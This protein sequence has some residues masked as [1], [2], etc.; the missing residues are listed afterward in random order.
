[1]CKMLVVKYFSVT[2]FYILLTLSTVNFIYYFKMYLFDLNVVF[3]THSQP[4]S[5]SLDPGLKTPAGAQHTWTTNYTRGLSSCSKH[6]LLLFSYKI[7][8][9]GA[10]IITPIITY[11]WR[12]FW[13]RKRNME[14]FSCWSLWRAY[15]KMFTVSAEMNKNRRDLWK[16]V[17]G[18]RLINNTNLYLENE[19]DHLVLKL[20][21]YK[22]NNKIDI[23][24]VS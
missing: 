23:T 6:I 2:F 12:S 3:L 21:A 7:Y 16:R 22:F 9:K 24:V 18:Q 5:R 17:L 15:W 13:G 4:P 10:W 19:Y 14:I 8:S 1:M 11:L 20:S